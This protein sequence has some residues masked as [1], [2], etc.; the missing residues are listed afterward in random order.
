MSLGEKSNPTKP[1]CYER[2]A[3]KKKYLVTSTQTAF[4]VAYLWDCL[5]QIVFSNASF[6]SLAKVY[7]N[8]HFLNLP[9]DVMLRRI[10]VN[11]KRIAEGIF[12]FTFLE[13]G[14][15]YGVP[16]IIFGGIDET[17][18]K[19]KIC[20]RDQFRK[21]W[22]VDHLCEVKGCES[23]IIIDGGMKPTRSLCAA[24]LHGLREFSKSGMVVV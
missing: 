9:T 3:L 17:I 4:S 14:Q 2:E 20:I 24:K 8:L 5:L 23:V 18:L 19:N 22:S 11:R 10:E 21:I 15:R 16:P 6:E 7:N 13:L 12:L 1:R